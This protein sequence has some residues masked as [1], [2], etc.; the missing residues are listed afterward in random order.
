MLIL[1]SI[2]INITVLPMYKYLE[3]YK[4]VKEGICK[5]KLSTALESL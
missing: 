3:F 4:S 1:R 2:S 5:I